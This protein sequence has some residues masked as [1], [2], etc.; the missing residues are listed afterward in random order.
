MGNLSWTLGFILKQGSRFL[1]WLVAGNTFYIKISIS[2]FFSVCLDLVWILEKTMTKALITAAQE[3]KSYHTIPSK[4]FYWGAALRGSSERELWFYRETNLDCSLS[5]STYQLCDVG[6]ITSYSL[7]SVSSILKMETI[8][9][10][11]CRVV[12]IKWHS[13]KGFAHCLVHVKY[14]VTISCCHYA[15]V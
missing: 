14:T 5:S 12:R 11:P 15:T 13:M 8:I 1:L 7:V 10:V 3:P 6:Q 2:H 9:Y 4:S